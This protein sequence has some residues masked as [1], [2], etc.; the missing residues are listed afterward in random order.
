M[1]HLTNHTF[2]NEKQN[3]FVNNKA[4]VTN[5]IETADFLTH[6]IANKNSVDMVLLDFA[7]A[8]DKVPHKN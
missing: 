5:L 7:K 3:G 2:I 8:F 4:C 6:N 1:S